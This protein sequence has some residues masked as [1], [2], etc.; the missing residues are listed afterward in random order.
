MSKKIVCPNCGKEIELSKSDYDTILSQV[1]DE[2]FS[3]ELQERIELV[4]E[5][6]EADLKLRIEEVKQANNKE[7]EELKEQFA[8]DLK[9]KDEQIAHLRDLKSKLSTKMLG[10][11]LEQHCQ[12]SFNQIRVSAFPNATFGKDNE[13]SEASGSK[14][15]Y[16]YREQTTEGAEL[17]SIMFEMKNEDDTTAKKHK[18]SDF[19][20]ELDKDR[21]EKGCEYA[22]L[23]TTLEADNDFYNAGIVNVS[24]E[25]PKMYVVRPQ[26]FITIITLL[27][28][29]A[30][31]A[32]EY[33]NQ[34]AI[35]R[36]KSVDVADFEENLAQFQDAFGKN[37]DLAKGKYEEA[38]D[39]I[40]KT[41]KQLEKV[42]ELFRLSE[43][44][45]R[46][47]NDKAQGLTVKKLI[48]GNPTMEQK[49]AEA[50]KKKDE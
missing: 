29:A 12:N 24:Y 17:I 19:F 37:Y 26:C 6:N 8:K 3:N 5:K 39:N 48:K 32:G 13:V 23:V 10:E 46:L 44:N 33:K 38:I 22:V 43:K 50:K 31:N 47:A 4:R 20:K 15:D 28:E 35:E 21:N 18:I 11:T 1:K 34:L 41:I 25:Y 30:L 7:I 40:D 36:A 14:G 45:L 49:F 27:R 9:D 16:I 2:A 42:K